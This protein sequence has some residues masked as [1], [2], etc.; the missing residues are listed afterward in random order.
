MKVKMW[1]VVIAKQ[2]SDAV[3]ELMLQSCQMHKEKLV[4]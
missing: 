4:N 2:Y 3:K 1:A